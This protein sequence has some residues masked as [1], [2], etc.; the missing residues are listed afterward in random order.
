MH[1]DEC[2]TTGS[3]PT[4]RTVVLTLRIELASAT[5]GETYRVE[6][7]A[8]LDSDPTAA[9]FATIGE[10]TVLGGP[11]GQAIAP[12]TPMAAPS[13]PVATPVAASPQFTG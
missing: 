2:L 7:S 1:L 9:V 12:P 3:G 4:G 5:A 8:A 13:Q 10:L 11:S 6:G